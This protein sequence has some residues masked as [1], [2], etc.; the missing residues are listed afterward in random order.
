MIELVKFTKLG[1][2]DNKETEANAYLASLGRGNDD[3]PENLPANFV[4]IF[5]CG[6]GLGVATKTK[7]LKDIIKA[8]SGQARTKDDVAQLPEALKNI[9]SSDA[10]FE[11]LTSPTTQGL[12]LTHKRKRVG[13]IVVLYVYDKSKDSQ[14]SET[15]EIFKNFFVK[16]FK[17]PESHFIFIPLDEILV[18]PESPPAA[19]YYKKFSEETKE[20]LRKVGRNVIKSFKDDMASQLL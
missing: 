3:I 10:T 5:G 8:I 19:K 6:P 9:I 12:D 18:T 17:V 16:Y 20:K 7:S 14:M 1:K 13:Q 4:I 2:V 15:R 11:V